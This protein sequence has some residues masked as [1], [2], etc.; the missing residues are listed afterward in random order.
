MIDRRAFMVCTA[1]LALETS[2]ARAQSQR[3]TKT[4]GVLYSYAEDDAEGQRFQSAFRRGLESLGWTEGRNLRFEIRWSRGDSERVLTLAK[5]L[6][7]LKPDTILTHSTQLVAALG[8]ATRD[9]P[10]VFA[11]A[12]DPVESGLVES[13]A[14]PGGNITG[15]STL[16]FANNGKLLELLKEVAPHVSRVAV[17]RNSSNPSQPGRFD[18]IAAVGKILDMDVSAIELRTPEEI[19]GAIDAFAATA[20]GGMI[21]LPGAFAGTH[22]A[23]IIAAAARRRLGRL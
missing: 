17:L 15:F 4:I 14:R 5:E 19:D 8:K 18:G 9:T 13:L 11:G 3:N 23:R 6:A 7:T 2:T 1:S 10:I 12:S 22:R 21:V 20:G 16:Q